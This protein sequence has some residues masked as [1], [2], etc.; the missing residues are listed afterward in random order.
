M[1]VSSKLG[2]SFS[3]TGEGKLRDER[4]GWE[5][6]WGLDFVIVHE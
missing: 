4:G 5:W 6:C 1:F 2:M 3:F